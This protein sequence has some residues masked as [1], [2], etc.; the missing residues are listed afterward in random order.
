LELFLMIDDPGRVFLTTD[1]PNGGPFTSYPHL[2]GLLCDRS[3]RETAL[4]EIHA[5]A[6]ASSELR[7]ISREY[8]LAEIAEMTRGGPARILGLS[9]RGHLRPGA[10]A[11]VVVYECDPDV[12]RMFARP[13][14]VFRRGRMVRGPGCEDPGEV[15]PLTVRASPEY[16][17]ASVARFAARYDDASSLAMRSL[18]I[19]DEE[20]AEVIGS[21]SV[22][23][24]GR[25]RQ[26]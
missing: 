8:T 11:D 15:P 5:D 23:C 21:R 13:K 1:H 4:A 22:A 10:V 12:E 14:Y 9:D 18:W 20:M 7:G 3:R 6:A 2:I 16:D 26:R 25:P 24:D 19:G 17:Q